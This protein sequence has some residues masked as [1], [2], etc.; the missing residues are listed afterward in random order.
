MR[1]VIAAAVAV[2]AA[3]LCGAAGAQAASCNYT[4]AV[5]GS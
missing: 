1:F 4:G 5:G 3:L 2:T